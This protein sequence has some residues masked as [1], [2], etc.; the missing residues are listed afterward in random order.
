MKLPHCNIPV[1]YLLPVFCLVL[2]CCGYSLR[3][4]LPPHLRT[5]A[6]PPCQNSTMQPGLGDQLT[7]LLTAAFSRDRSLRVGT[8][9]NADLAVNTTITAY[10]RT[11]SVYDERQNI[12]TYDLAAS[13]QVEAH[14]QVRDETFFSGSVSEKI[15]YNPAAETEEAAATRLLQ[16]LAA[17]IVR[18]VI[19]TW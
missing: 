6:V 8:P 16:A 10:S 17:E 15:T 13:A 2:S 12:S 7:E 9:E 18:R 5:V 19:T 4:L 3:S 11:A 14:D 1:L